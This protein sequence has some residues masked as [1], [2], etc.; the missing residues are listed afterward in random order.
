MDNLTEMQRRILVAAM[1]A[2][3]R[4]IFWVLS[5]GR[6]V[7]PGFTE[8]ASDAVRTLRGAGLLTVGDSE[9]RSGGDPAAGSHI[10]KL[11]ESGLAAARRVVRGARSLRE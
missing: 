6:F 10:L 5:G 9:A 11:T 7:I 4:L 8:D 3:G 1:V 2:S